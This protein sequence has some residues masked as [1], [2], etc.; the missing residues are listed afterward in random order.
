M[1]TGRPNENLAIITV[2][3]RCGTTYTFFKQY[4]SFEDFEAFAIRYADE[5]VDLLA[6]EIDKIEKNIRSEIPQA[7]HM[8]LEAD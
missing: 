7:E 6:D 1:G 8:D 4:K 3:S 2:H 5:I